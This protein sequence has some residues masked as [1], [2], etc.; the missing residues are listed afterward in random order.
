MKYRGLF[1]G[2]TTLDCIYLSQSN[3]QTNQKIVAIDH[4]TVAGGPAT[5]AAVAFGSL[6]N[7]GILMNVLGEHPLSQI[8]KQELSAFD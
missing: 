3:L 5:N 4:L 6:G 1:I 8:I 7:Q 2:L